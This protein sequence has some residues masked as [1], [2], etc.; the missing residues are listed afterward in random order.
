MERSGGELAVEIGDGQRPDAPGDVW[1]VA[2]EP[3]V[4]EIAVGEGENAHRVMK[5]YN[6]VRT[7][8]RIGGWSGDPVRLTAPVTDDLSYAVLVQ[9]AALGAMIATAVEGPPAS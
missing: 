6:V 8:T 5:T 3:G 4:H 1:L 2:Y 7:I 9:G